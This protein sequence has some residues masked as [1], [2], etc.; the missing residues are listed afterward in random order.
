MITYTIA[1]PAPHTHLFH[2]QIEL[3]G[4]HGDVLD[5]ILPSWTPGSY[6]IREYA[7]HVQAFSA[8]HDDGS[9]LHWQKQAKDCWR[10]Q[11]A[12]ATRIMVSYH[13]YAN[14]L[15][16]RTSHLDASHGYFNGAAV[17]MYAE[18]RTA[19]Q[20]R[21]L[22]EPPPDWHVTTALAPLPG[23]AL[24]SEPRPGRFYFVATDYDELV[25]SPVECGTHRLFHFEVDQIRHELAIWGSG[26]EDPER[27][28]HDTERIVKAQRDFFGSLP[29]PRY[30]IILHLT[31][32]KGGGLEHRNSVTNQLDRWSFRPERS[33]ERYLAL[34][35]HELFHV[36]NGKRLRPAV[37][38]PFDYRHET[39]TRLLWLVEGATSYY[40]KLL[41]VRAGLL[42][43]E[44]YLEKL[45][46]EI[47]NLQHQPG[48]LCQSLEQSSFDAWIKLYRPDEN[49]A[50]VSISYYQKGSLVCL[51]LDMRL[52][53]ASN[54]ARSLDDL[55]RLLYAS[56]PLDE[57]GL[58][59]AGAV[60]AAA[61]AVASLPTGSLDDFFARYIAG[62]AELA[63]AE[64]FAVV[65]L[66]L[67]W[68]HRGPAAWL[69]IN[70]RQHGE[71]AMISSVRSDGPAYAAGVN[72]NDELLAL[73]G[74][75][76]SEERMNARLAERE[77]GT[78]VTLSLFRGDRLIELPVTLAEAPPDNLSL[79]TVA[80]PTETQRR[81][82]QTWLGG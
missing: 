69:G 21:L 79:R 25:D 67:A 33:Y 13:V 7:R 6:M 30:T 43:R 11:T 52:R 15:S 18:G 5:L 73:D 2:V 22:I 44:R 78:V 62:T 55:L 63:Y 72:A 28:V 29:Y 23:D 10:V 20:I 8:T 51:L 34:T 47:I 74:W 60:Q 71:R 14:D 46:D 16:V 56:Y 1:M 50:N 53:A 40:D 31:D 32:G 17:F 80:T 38:G 36:W 3:D 65:G 68:M 75:R 45:A 9:P 64:A 58:P 54:G 26:N 4:L 81:N 77:P 41:L 37:L 19:E 27:L 35:S 12:G 49:S 70:V 24:A 61:E 48:R 59:E 39:Y 76:V 66:E 42:R 57:P 82:L